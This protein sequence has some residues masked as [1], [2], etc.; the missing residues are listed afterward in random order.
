MRLT[1]DRQFLLAG[2]ALAA[3]GVGALATTHEVG[4][5]YVAL[6]LGGLGWSL[7]RDWHRSKLEI[8]SAAANVAI[9]AAL[10]MSMAPVVLR[11][12]SPVRAIAEFL[13][14]LA[15]L[16]ALAR[17]ENRDWL[18]IYVLSFFQLL[19]AAALTV[20][21][22]FAL[23]FLAYLVLAPCVLVLFQLRRE[24]GGST[25]AARLDEEPFVEPSLFR[26]LAATTILLFL[27]T[28]TIFVVFP[29]VGAGYFAAPFSGGQVLTGF[30]E[31]VGLGSF[32]A[33]KQ[34][35]AIAM[36]V[37]VDRPAV[38]AGAKWRGVALDHF[39]GRNWRRLPQE[40]RPMMR[41]EYGVFAS[42]AA[43]KPGSLVSEDVI[44]EPQD[45]SALFVAGFPL[46]LRG[47][48]AE[49][50]IDALG[51]LRVIRP[52]GVRT[53]Y[54]V[55]ASIAPRRM[56]PTRQT[57][58][59]PRVDPRIVDVARSR[60]QGLTS[61]QQRADALLDYFHH[62]FRYSLE[63]TNPG[64]EDPLVHFLFET[65]TGFCEHFASAYAVMLRVIGIPSLVVNGYSGGEWNSYGNYFVVRQS[66]AHSW[67]EAYVDGE[68]RTFDPTPPGAA[69]ERSWG[70][71]IG[72]AIDAM[73]MRW[74][75]YVINFTLEDQAQAALTFRDATQSFWEGLWRNWWTTP[76]TEQAD[77]SKRA[78]WRIPWRGF[79]AGLCLA[80]LVA[81]L[82]R[83]RRGSRAATAREDGEV[84][85]RYLRLL[86]ALAAAG[87]E[88]RPA[89]TPVELCRRI[90]ARLDGPAD[91]VARATALYHEARF[92]GRNVPGADLDGEIDAAIA[93]L[94]AAEAA[95]PRP[96][97]D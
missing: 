87:F 55:I 20:E 95:V 67:V 75:R 68:W 71:R 45:S 79:A 73:Q 90:A 6:A 42:G 31:E 86:R 18:Q 26:S 39:D 14:V 76:S 40:A 12:A 58:Q 96:G 70:R 78:D 24:V 74:Y 11:G 25:S 92:S 81:W 51:N 64:S 44:L 32:A 8:S 97:A 7:W 10:C 66:D 15:A 5:P 89:E 41:P 43:A 57:L 50:S 22:V 63:A 93:A 84:T 56:P 3:T 4:A 62:G 2:H 52:I 80:S 60:V 27:S 23:L 82:W 19:A 65:R 21:P 53:R 88:K 16:K 35:S 77:Q 1:F 72:D 37:T 38:L 46:E 29:R 54:Q 91:A 94:R 48:F 30:T 49:A 34:D 28:L 17:K 36:R 85:R 61:D 59:L 83:R 33:L 9:L 13:L 69:I 47:R